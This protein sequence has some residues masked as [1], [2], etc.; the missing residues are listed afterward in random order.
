M[1]LMKEA[2]NH[3]EDLRNDE[4]DISDEDEDLEDSNE[5]VCSNC[6]CL[7]RVY[8]KKRNWLTCD[9]CNQFICPVCMAKGA[10]ILNNN[11]TAKNC[12]Q[13]SEIVIDM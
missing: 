8:R 10:S 5:T 1:L 7:R 11:F 3:A 6:N 12:I 2:E 9:I 4:N 13:C